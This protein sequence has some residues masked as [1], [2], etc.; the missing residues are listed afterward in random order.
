MNTELIVKIV[1]IL[2]VAVPAL[3][4]MY[5][6]WKKSK[7]WKKIGLI[8][9]DFIEHQLENK[10]GKVS[11]VEKK[12]LQ[13]MQEIHGVSSM[14]DSELDEVRKKRLKDADKNGLEVG[15]DLTPGG[16]W[17]VGAKWRRSF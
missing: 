16:K 2:V 14:V 5:F 12:N 1:G 7:D 6:V 17:N 13:I 3:L 15:V 11:H 10:E 9:L 8:G 4:K